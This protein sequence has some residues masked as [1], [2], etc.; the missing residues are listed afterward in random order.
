M[1]RYEIITPLQIEPGKPAIEPGETIELAPREGD[2]LVLIGALRALS[3]KPRPTAAPISGAGVLA[4]MT[5]VSL[6]AL[7]EK[8]SANVQA[9][10]KKADIIA[11]IEARRAEI[12]DEQAGAG[13]GTE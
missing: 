7:A 12:A 8:E 5:V 2:A 9:G 4:D 11:A 1:K 10:A 3:G 13:D 6:L